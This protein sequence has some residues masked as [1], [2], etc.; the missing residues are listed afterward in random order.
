MTIKDLE[1]ELKRL[2]KLVYYDELTGL[3]NRRGFTEETERIFRGSA[4]VWKR[5]RSRNQSS[6]V[7]FSVMFIDADN[8]K[9][10]NDAFGHDTGDSVLKKISA[11]LR[12]NLRESD[13]IARWGGEEF[14]VALFGSP[15]HDAPA[16][17]ERIRQDIE[18][19][20]LPK[21]ASRRVRVT[22]SIGIATYSGENSLAT[23]INHAD[24]AMYQAKRRG[25]NRT[26]I[27]KDTYA[28]A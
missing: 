13:I 11:L 6:D 24:Q 1:R 8:F 26:L 10:V 21:K 28:S 7:A 9:L 23:L 25:K 27:Y 16:V 20:K 5:K 19:M 22:V 17:A 2:R 4:A 18:D 12:K 3:F 15:A 14:V